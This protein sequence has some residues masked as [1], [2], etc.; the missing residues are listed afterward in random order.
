MFQDLVSQY[1]SIKCGL[2]TDFI[3][4]YNIPIDAED[5]EQQEQSNRVASG[6]NQ[7][8]IQKQFTISILNSEFETLNNSESNFNI[9]TIT[10]FDASRISGNKNKENH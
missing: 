2:S 10:D 5:V 1:G 4:Q 6:E 3:R 8:N 9:D 7:Q